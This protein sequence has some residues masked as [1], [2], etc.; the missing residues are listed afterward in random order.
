M[1]RPDPAVAHD[2][3]IAPDAVLEVAPPVVARR[4]VLIGGGLGVASLVLPSAMAA[5]SVPTVQP[6]GGAFSYDDGSG[7][8][9][10]WKGFDTNSAGAVTGTAVL[11][12]AGQHGR[13]GTGDLS[14]VDPRVAAAG[15][16]LTYVQASGTITG[17]TSGAVVTVTADFGGAFQGLAGNLAV[18]IASTSGGLTVTVSDGTLTIDLDGADQTASDV[19]ARI[20]DISGLTASAVDGTFTVADAGN[21]AS[22]SGGA[23]VPASSIWN[24]QSTTNAL[25]MDTSPHLQWTITNNTSDGRTLTVSTLVLYRVRNLAANTSGTLNLAFYTS[26]DAGFDSPVLRR[27]AAFSNGI[28][29]H[30]VVPVGPGSGVTLAPGDTLTVRAFPYSTPTPRDV[31]LVQYD[32]NDGDPLGGLTNFDQASVQTQTA[33]VG[34]RTG[35]GNTGDHVSAFI[36]RFAPLP[37]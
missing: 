4:G 26:T 5:A 1:D 34:A 30:L 21:Y 8:L 2:V 37:S 16:T 36:G 20:S 25:D 28:T 27:T 6:T 14:N 3:T 17:E 32:S 9:V 19:A 12:V 35:P 23:D 18:V 10:H 11:N 15:T 33:V 13:G 7:V 24:M 31:R 22:L 29:K